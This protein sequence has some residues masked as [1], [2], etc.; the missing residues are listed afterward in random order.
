MNKVYKIVEKILA[1]G[2]EQVTL[3]R[4]QA[5]MLVDGAKKT[6]SKTRDKET[7]RLRLELYRAEEE[8]RAVADR[9]KGARK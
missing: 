6:A 1:S 4:K 2:V 5:E 9:M 7:Q 3:T 8:I